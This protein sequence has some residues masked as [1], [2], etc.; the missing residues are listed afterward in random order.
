MKAPFDISVRQRRLTISFLFI[1]GVL[2]YI[3]R[4]IISVLQVPIKTELGLSDTQLGLLTG[5]AFAALYVVSAI[6]ISR[7][8][9]RSSRKM[10]IVAS[11]AVWSI[12]TAL[13]AAAS[14]FVLLLVCRMG[15]AIG[16][17]GSV[18]ATHSTL[19]DLYPPKKRARAIATWALCLPFGMIVGYLAAGRMADA[20]GWRMTFMVIG[21]IGVA[22]API[23]M[24]CMKEPSRGR[25]DAHAGTAVRGDLKSALLTLWR[26]RTY[27]YLVAGGAVHAF[28]QYSLMLWNAPFYARVHGESLTEVSLYLALLN[29]AGGGVGIYVGG[30]LADRLG[31]RDMKW[32]LLVPALAILIMMPLAMLQ[33]FVASPLMSVAI[34]FLPSALLV[35]YLAPI[36]AVPMLVVGPHMRAFASAVMTVIFNVVGLGLGPLVTGIISDAF[37]THFG[38]ADDS[39]R[40]ALIVVL[41]PALLASFLFWKAAGSLSGDMLPQGD[42]GDSLPIAEVQPA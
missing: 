8:A 12:M 33:Y 15:V 6:P 28:V 24:L 16:E 29:G 22:L 20:L 11:M 9:D 1:V 30:W 27:R 21:G 19:A 4:T 10:V 35:F 17:S 34:G 2:N 13:T 38:M 7:I 42:E 36:V 39:L 25:F 23:A 37:I 3:D 41:L 5:L 32:Q 31:R 18:P 14:S 26:I 40:Y